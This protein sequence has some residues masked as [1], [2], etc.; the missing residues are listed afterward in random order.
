MVLIPHE[1]NGVVAFL[2]CTI[3]IRSWHFCFTKQLLVDSFGIRLYRIF[4]K[5]AFQ[6]SKSEPSRIKKRQTDNFF[7]LCFITHTFTNFYYHQE[8]PCK[9]EE[10]E[11][12]CKDKQAKCGQDKI[13]Q[14]CK[15]TCG[16]C[17]ETPIVT[18]TPPNV[19]YDA[20]QKTWTF[21]HITKEI[22]LV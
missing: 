17:Q 1:F 9:N 20:L 22:G 13:K 14:K 8:T 11:K 16:Q 18:P 2:Y 15:K 10:T 19:S 6:P 4:L 7:E 12:F 3:P 21:W 5:P